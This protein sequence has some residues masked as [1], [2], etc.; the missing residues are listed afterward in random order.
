MDDISYDENLVITGLNHI[1]LAVKDLDNSFSFYKNILGFKPR[2]RWAEGAYFE[3]GDLWFC[4]SVD[5]QTS[6]E[7]LAEYTHIAFSVKQ[8][9]FKKMS[10]R[11]KKS[12]AIIWKENKSEGD[13]LYFLDPD[14]HKLELHVGDIETR[15]KEKKGDDGKWKNIEWFFD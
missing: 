14:G 11:I 2:I 12:G 6:I 10:E 13:S 5:S 1:T 3:V 4:L 8:D 15:L 7:M 9:D